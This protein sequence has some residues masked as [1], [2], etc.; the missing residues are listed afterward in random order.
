MK[1]GQEYRQSAYG[2]EDA[3]AKRKMRA[4]RSYTCEHKREWAWGAPHGEIKSE[5]QR[6]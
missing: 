5:L 6:Q 2:A 4:P 1:N 3:K